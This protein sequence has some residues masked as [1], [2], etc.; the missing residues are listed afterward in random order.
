MKLFNVRLKC[1]FCQNEF[2]YNIITF[3]AKHECNQCQ[4]DLIVRTKPTV[5]TMISMP[6][7]FV[8]LALRETFGISKMP[9]AINLIYIII[10]CILYIGFTYKLLSKIKTPTY[11]YQVDA[12]DPTLLKRYKGSKKK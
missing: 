1:P 6:G 2:D 10:T 4:N 3:K 8:I 12:Q 7:F 11:I 9:L 5:S